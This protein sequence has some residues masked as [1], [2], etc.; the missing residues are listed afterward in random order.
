MNGV[1]SEADLKTNW[2][3]P[4][5]L[6]WCRGL[7]MNCFPGWLRSKLLLESGP[8]PLLHPHP[9]CT[10]TCYS[11]AMAILDHCASVTHLESAINAFEKCGPAWWLPSL[12][13]EHQCAKTSTS[14]QASSVMPCDPLVHTLLLPHK[15]AS[16]CRGEVWSKPDSPS[17][18]LHC[19]LC[20]PVNLIWCGQ[21]WLPSLLS[22]AA[23]SKPVSNLGEQ[24][25]FKNAKYNLGVEYGHLSITFSI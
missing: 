3:S 15:W 22:P 14:H 19:S 17:S 16:A 4:G 18:Q 5:R 11:N 20:L 25:L 7:A 13:A 8:Q 6:R 24:H 21:H 9:H 12:F 10:R 2:N 23:K 1:F